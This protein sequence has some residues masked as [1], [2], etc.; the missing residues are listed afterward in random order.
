MPGTSG[1]GPATATLLLVLSFPLGACT[2]S[3]LRAP[4][5]LDKQAPGGLLL[6]VVNHHT[7]DIRVH[8]MRG[9]SS[10]PLGS[11][12]TLERRTFVV[13]NSLMGHSGE[14]RLMADPLGGRETRVSPIISA[15]PGD[16]VNWRIALHPNASTLV[17]RRSR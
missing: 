14:L 2:S 1:L 11:L 4:G 15:G 6:T 9:A 17:V 8:V 5:P 10:F 13:P 7:S 16:H 12:S 3:Q